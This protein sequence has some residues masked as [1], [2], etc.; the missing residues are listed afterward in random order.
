MHD[1]L[2]T[3]RSYAPQLWP[4][5]SCREPGHTAASKRPAALVVK[6]GRRHVS[7]QLALP[8]LQVDQVESIHFY[9]GEVSRKDTY[10]EVGGGGQGYEGPDLTGAGRGGGGEGGMGEWGGR[11]EV[12]ERCHCE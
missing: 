3:I 9:D 6:A 2:R 1:S 12:N 5:F 10:T 11:G 7:R 4:I 8:G